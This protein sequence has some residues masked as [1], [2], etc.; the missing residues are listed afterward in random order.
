MQF[1]NRI[2]LFIYRI[3]KKNRDKTNL[4]SVW[5]EQL[6]ITKEHFLSPDTAK[7]LLQRINAHVVIAHLV[8]TSWI[9][10]DLV[11]NK[12]AQ[13]ATNECIRPLPATTLEDKGFR[14]E[15]FVCVCAVRTQDVS[16]VRRW[17][18][19]GRRTQDEDIDQERRLVGLPPEHLQCRQTVDPST[20]AAPHNGIVYKHWGAGCFSK[21]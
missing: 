13:P 1:I 7:P 19:A 17:R 3:H 4:D 9:R 18:G 20:S 14:S 6:F 5:V 10:K 2:R 11:R 21:I 15:R 8:I 12:L 16:V